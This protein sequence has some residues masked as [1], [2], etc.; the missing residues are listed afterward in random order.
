MSRT[1]FTKGHQDFDREA[2]A[3]FREKG[4][5]LRQG[6]AE[7]RREQVQKL[8]E[9]NV[10]V[11]DISTELQTC[12]RTIRRDIRI[13]RDQGAL[14]P[15]REAIASKA[16]ALSHMRTAFQSR[17]KEKSERRVRVWALH[18]Q[19][20]TYRQIAQEL[21]WKLG[22]VTKDIELMKHLEATSLESILYALSMTMAPPVL[23]RPQL[24][25][26]VNLVGVRL[27]I[28]EVYSLH[29]AAKQLGIAHW[30]MLQLLERAAWTS[31]EGLLPFTAYERC[32]TQHIWAF[33]VGFK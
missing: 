28:G 32:E 10:A 3:A 18:Q 2:L 17:W 26:I 16:N 15:F 31:H 5:K 8:F 19:G 9:A 22:T 27:E 12:L 29:R 13:L 14:P 21:N 4:L 7:A 23:C 30:R 11:D 1:T 24:K 6:R 25:T 20:L 33:R